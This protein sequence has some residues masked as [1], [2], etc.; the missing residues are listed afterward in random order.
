MALGLLPAQPRCC[1]AEDWAIWGD[2]GVRTCHLLPTQHL[3]GPRPLAGDPIPVPSSRS[4]PHQ[5]PS[6]PIPAAR[7]GGPGPRRGARSTARRCAAPAPPSSPR[8]AAERAAGQRPPGSSRRA[9]C[10]PTT[11]GRAEAEA[12][13]AA[14]APT[15]RP[16]EHTCTWRLLPQPG[17]RENSRAEL[18]STSRSTWGTLPK[19]KGLPTEITWCCISNFSPPQAHALLL[20]RVPLTCTPPGSSGTPCA[21]LAARQTGCR[22]S[23]AREQKWRLQEEGAAPEQRVGGAAGLRKLPAG[24][25]KGPP[26]RGGAGPTLQR[27]VR[28]DVVQEEADGEDQADEEQPGPGEAAA[29]HLLQQHLG[30]TSTDPVTS[31]LPSLAAPA[32]KDALRGEAQ[33]APRL[34]GE[35]WAPALRDFGPVCSSAASSPHAVPTPGTAFLGGAT[36][37][38]PQQLAGTS[39]ACPRVP[40]VLSGQQL[41]PPGT[42]SRAPRSPCRRHRTLPR[43]ARC[44]APALP[45][46]RSS[47]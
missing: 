38:A 8:A 10:S 37:P 12:A 32:L 33:A 9:G 44:P 11:C 36:K 16:R 18:K 28:P 13:P 39:T 40:W 27:A 6:S 24:L 3:A 21:R 4:A 17:E 14:P 45:A 31:L 22:R 46:P 29:L 15:A 41:S 47:P 43:P 20:D 7:A 35:L 25:K 42:G 19:Q 34:Q 5:P 2:V 23:G 26:A 30:D 1:W